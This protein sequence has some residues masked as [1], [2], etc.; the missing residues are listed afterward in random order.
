MMLKN[1]SGEAA[2]KQGFATSPLMNQLLSL[3]HYLDFVI[4]NIGITG[5]S[6]FLLAQKR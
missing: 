4:P 6:A 2:I 3:L 1:L 5:T